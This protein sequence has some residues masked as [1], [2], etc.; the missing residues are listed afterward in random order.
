M[1]LKEILTKAYLNRVRIGQESYDIE[2]MLNY[3]LNENLDFN[4][5]KCYY[6]FQDEKENT[7][8]SLD[9]DQEL[10]LIDNNSGHYQAINH[11][12]K[13][14]DLFFQITLPFKQ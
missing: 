12:R 3:S 4:V 5:N 1:L 8:V 9:I 10:K 14:V 7:V 6:D 2:Y 11:E 13:I